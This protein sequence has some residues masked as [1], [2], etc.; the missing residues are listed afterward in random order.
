MNN[1]Y[2]NLQN[3]SNDEHGS[4]TFDE[5]VRTKGIIIADDDA[6]K[7]YQN[8]DVGCSCRSSDEINNYLTLK[9]TDQ[10][11]DYI[12]KAKHTNDVNRDDNS[13]DENIKS[14]DD[15]FHDKGYRLSEHSVL[16][17]GIDSFKPYYDILDLEKLRKGDEIKFHF[18]ISTTASEDKAVTF[19]KGETKILLELSGLSNVLCIF[20]ENVSVL[21]MAD[22]TNKEQEV[23]INRNTTLK[24]VSIVDV[25]CK[26][27]QQIRKI[28]LKIKA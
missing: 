14:I 10:V 1:M 21:G 12:E 8:L 17:K 22:S 23:V 2:E 4:N 25:V 24:V 15:V 5:F 26:S 18:Y 28:H 27:G 3:T 19:C 9:Y 7:G 13:L 20:P 16:F 6:I 11:D